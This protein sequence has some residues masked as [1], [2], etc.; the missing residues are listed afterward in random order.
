MKVQLFTEIQ[1]EFQ[2]FPE[3]DLERFKNRFLNSELGKIYKAIPW[4]DLVRDFNI[5]VE[6]T[7]RPF[8]FHAHG[9]LDLMFLKNYSNLS[10]K[11]LIEQ[12][13]GNIEWQFFCGI[14]LGHKRIDNYKIVSQIRCELSEKLNIEKLQKTLFDYWSPHIEETEKITM[15]ATCYESEVR[16]PTDVK[17]LWESVEWSYNRMRWVSKA[18][19]QRQ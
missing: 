8:L 5:K 18:L 17:L 15:D 3:Q 4:K 12:L 14:Y 19:E 7:G 2:F 10:D 11:R 13:N 1:K 6:P 16:Y 9:R